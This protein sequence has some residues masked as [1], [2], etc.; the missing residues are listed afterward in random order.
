MGERKISV[1]PKKLTPAAEQPNLVQ[2]LAA[3]LDRIHRRNR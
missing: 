1:R 3:N 2:K